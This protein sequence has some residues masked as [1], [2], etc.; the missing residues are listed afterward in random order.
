[1]QRF[2][3][4]EFGVDVDRLHAVE[5]AKSALAVKSNIRRAIEKEGI[6]YTYVVSN[7]FNGYFLPTLMQ[8]GLTS[9]PTHKVIIPGDGHPKGQSLLTNQF[10]LL[11][12]VTI[13]FYYFSL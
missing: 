13:S 9:P 8:H 12:V 3:P 4:S 6:P 10:E 2:F 11:S 7:C 1:M 5:P